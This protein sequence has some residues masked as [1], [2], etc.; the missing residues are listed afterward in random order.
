MTANL[1][2]NRQSACLSMVNKVQP[3]FVCKKKNIGVFLKQML[4]WQSPIKIHLQIPFWRE[5]VTWRQKS[6]KRTTIINVL[7]NG[8][9]SGCQQ[10]WYKSAHKMLASND[11]LNNEHTKHTKASSFWI[12]T[13]ADSNFNKKNK[14]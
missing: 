3:F 14:T 13:W 8:F 10:S 6:N 4:L 9:S 5:N 1:L 2:K 12:K 7:N 11:F